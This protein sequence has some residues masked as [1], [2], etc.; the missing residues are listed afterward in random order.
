MSKICKPE[1]QDDSEENKE[2]EPEITT[3]HL[4]T[5]IKEH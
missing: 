5:R 4:L 1:V 2:E 3:R